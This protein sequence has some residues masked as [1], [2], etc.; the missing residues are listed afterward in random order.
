MFVT[1]STAA[2]G[3][4]SSQA[5]AASALWGMVT[6]HPAAPRARS[7]TSTSHTVPGATGNATY[8]QSRCN[9]AYAA[10]WMAGDREWLTGWPM[11]PVTV[12]CPL[13]GSVAKG[14]SGGRSAML[15]FCWASVVENA[16][17]PEASEI[18]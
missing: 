11:I 4:S 9:A 7:P 15:W 8:T 14:P 16:S 1:P 18:T 10:L 3:V 17:F 5:R 13:R 2:T 12:V 6:L